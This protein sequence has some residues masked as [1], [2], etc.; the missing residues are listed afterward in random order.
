MKR[1]FILFF[2][3]VSI[4]SAARNKAEIREIIDES[5]RKFYTIKL[6]S[7]DPNEYYDPYDVCFVEAQDIFVSVKD[8]IEDAEETGKRAEKDFE[9]KI[10]VLYEKN[11]DYMWERFPDYRYTFEEV[12]KEVRGRSIRMDY[13]DH[14]DNIFTCTIEAEVVKK[15]KSNKFYRKPYILGYIY[16]DDETKHKIAGS[17]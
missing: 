3:L 12:Y 5:G 17:D 6:N 10:R 2:T 14:I 7:Y 15:L 11:K 8:K 4:I 16:I 1:T 9:N 13:Y